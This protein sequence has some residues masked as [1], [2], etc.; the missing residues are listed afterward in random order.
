MTFYKCVSCILL[1][2]CVCQPSK[3][4]PKMSRVW[5]MSFKSDDE[6]ERER[7]M[8]L[9]CVAGSLSRACQFSRS[10][11]WKIIMKICSLFRQRCSHMYVINR[12]S[13]LISLARSL[14]DRWIS[15]DARHGIA[16][17]RTKAVYV[18]LVEM[19]I[20]HS[21]CYAFLFLI[22]R[23]V[24]YII[25]AAVIVIAFCKQMGLLFLLSLTVVAA[26][27]SS[28]NTLVRVRSMMCVCVESAVLFFSFIPRKLDISLMSRIDTCRDHLSR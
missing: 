22:Y 27:R 18:Y 12:D 28:S 24:Y 20:L 5:R 2:V 21:R 15:S 10:A 26:L 4:S 16:L 14:V 3:Q 9:L 6:R 1:P 13:V 7:V 25:A 8:F 19:Y 23:R 17:V 11:D